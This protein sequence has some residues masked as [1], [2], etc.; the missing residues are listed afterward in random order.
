M[1]S[2]DLVQRS[3]PNVSALIQCSRSCTTRRLPIARYQEDAR[4]GRRDPVSQHCKRSHLPIAWDQSTYVAAAKAEK[5]EEQAPFGYGAGLAYALH[6]PEGRHLLIGIDRDG[7]LPKKP[8]VLASLIGELQLLSVYTLD[9]AMK[10]LGQPQP[11]PDLPA[12]TARERE[13]LRWTM[14]GK[15]AWELGMILGIS[16]Q[17]A[18]R[19][20]NNAMHKLGCVSKHQAVVKALGH[21]LIR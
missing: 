12:L 8:E 3:L 15:T 17:T 6:L 7:A 16:E 19:H 1:A 9:A 2:N 10:V 13:C 18:A 5:W 4:N 20:L 21:G 14:D 11:D